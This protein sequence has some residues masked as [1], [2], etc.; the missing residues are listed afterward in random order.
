M[1]S[2]SRRCSSFGRR[3][4]FAPGVRFEHTRGRAAG[5][6]DIGQRE[7]DRRVFGTTTPTGTVDRTSALYLQ[8]RYGGGRNY[9]RQDYDT[10]LR[11]L[12]TTYRFNE[13][14]VLKG[15][16]NQAI[17]RA[18]MNRLIG[19]LVVTNDDPNNPLPNRANAGNAN[20][21]PEL[22]KTI[23]LTLEYYTRGIGQISVSAFR[24]DFKDLIR[25]RTFLRARPAAR[26]TARR[27][28]RPSP[29][30]TGKSAPWTTSARRT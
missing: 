12:H 18:D 27:C 2:T 28:P 16:W 19:G 7:T 11:Y 26:G 23:N 25:S 22:S 29:R 14:L 6:A 13:R 30:R 20:L 24:R 5:P 15:S 9:A 8:T 17:S 10:W 1:R 3:L 21:R 4:T